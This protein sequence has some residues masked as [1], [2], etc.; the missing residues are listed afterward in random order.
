MQFVRTMG[1]GHGDVDKD[2]L[3]LLNARYEVCSNEISPPNKLPLDFQGL[4]LCLAYFCFF[5]ILSFREN[6]FETRKNVFYATLKSLFHL[7]IIK[8]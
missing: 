8:F 6:T 5:C 7:E 2:E 3:S 4:G 1:A